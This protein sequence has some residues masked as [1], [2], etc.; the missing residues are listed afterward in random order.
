VTLLQNI[1]AFFASKPIKFAKAVVAED[2]FANDNAKSWWGTFIIVLQSNVIY[3]FGGENGLIY[4]SGNLNASSSIETSNCPLMDSLLWFGGSGRNVYMCQV[5]MLS[6]A[7]SYHN[8]FSNLR[9]LRRSLQ[10]NYPLATTHPPRMPFC[11]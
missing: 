5:G 9:I 8:C 6:T 1:T 10:R 2:S 11:L 7:T 4:A 3:T